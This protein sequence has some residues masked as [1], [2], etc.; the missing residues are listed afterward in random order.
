MSRVCVVDDKELIRIA[1][2]TLSKY[3]GIDARPLCERVRRAPAAI[4]QYEA[5][6]R[7]RVQ[8]IRD[9]V[10]RHPGLT[11]RGNSYDDVSIVG[12]MARQC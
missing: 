12:Q 4:P 8:R 1:L 11:L 9:L 10:S 5:G 2:E 3:T 7:D 6:H